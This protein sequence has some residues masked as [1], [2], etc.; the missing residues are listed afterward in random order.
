MTRKPP[1]IDAETV[2]LAAS[3]DAAAVEAIVRGLQGPIHA[4]ARRMLLDRDDASVVRGLTP[5]EMQRYRAPFRERA[6]R[7]PVLAWPR[8]LPI[9]GEP[10]DV[11]ARVERYRDA[12]CRSDLPKLLF[13]VEPGVLVP[14]AVAAWCRAHLPRLEVIELGRGLHFVQEDHPH[15]IGRGLAGWLSRVPA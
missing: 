13:T 3:G 6:A 10:A 4:I 1:D 15:S 11:V 5:A 7:G 2:T 12:L 9:V 8:E 14:P